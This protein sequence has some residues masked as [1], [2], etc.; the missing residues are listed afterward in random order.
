MSA[1]DAAATDP[2][3]RDPAFRCSPWTHAQGVDPI[4]SAGSFDEL[5]L[6]EWPLPWPSDV[7]EV[8]A[9]A[10]AAAHP[11]ARV[12]LVVP[13]AGS[14]VDGMHRVVH[15]RRTRTHHL[16]GV[17]HAVAADEV[18][19]VL[20]ALLAEPDR[21]QRDWPTVVGVAPAEILVCGHGRRDPCC[22]RW[23]TLLH[24]DLAARGTSAR[25][26]RSSHTGGHRFAPTA[27]TLPDGRAWAYADADLLDRVLT[28]TG[29]VPSLAAHDRGCTALDMWA[30]AVERALFVEH[31]WA[32]LQAQVD[33]VRT[34]VA[35]DG[36]SASVD[37]QWRFDDGTHGRIRADVEVVRN[38]PV[39]V[40]GEPPEAAKKSSPELRVRRLSA[41]AG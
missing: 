33:E 17:D 32:W 10:E 41:V 23:G 16:D 34:E 27:I 29:D 12:M 19:A 25:I 18:T 15:R 24:A 8:E 2:I 5:L 4:G 35:D 28:R 36:G 39:L 40:C 1:L 9:L 31:G 3:P 22:G 38:L 37:L 26:W 11:R 30:Q 14:L 20:A 6:V 13:P 7:S 21:P